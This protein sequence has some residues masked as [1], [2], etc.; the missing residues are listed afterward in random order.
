M[1]SPIR[2]SLIRR[3]L[4]LAASAALTLGVAGAAA[5]AAAAGP[6]A[7]NTRVAGINVD[8][9]T[10]PQLQALMN[11]HRLTSV[12]LVQFYPH[13]IARLR[14]LPRT[15]PRLDQASSRKIPGFRAG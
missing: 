6:P 2:S 7:T 12:Q 15:S 13:R 4:A 9:T 14:W 8:A 1:R 5:P 3:S 11:R 10:I